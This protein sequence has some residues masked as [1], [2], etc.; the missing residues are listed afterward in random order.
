M[1]LP[2]FWPVAAAALSSWLLAAFNAMPGREAYQN[3]YLYAGG[4]FILLLAT[5]LLRGVRIGRNVLLV[6]GVVTVAA[7]SS[8]LVQFREGSRCIV[9]VHRERRG[10]AQVC[11]AQ[12]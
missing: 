8:N 2:R 10:H 11:V 1:V 4:L 7:V 6:A 12:R 3:R 9:G 5:E